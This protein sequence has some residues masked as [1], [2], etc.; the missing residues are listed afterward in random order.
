MEGLVC[1][2]PLPVIF[3]CV[4]LFL[5]SIKISKDHASSLKMSSYWSIVIMYL[6]TGLWLLESDPPWLQVVRWE[7]G[8]V[9]IARAKR[10]FIHQNDQ[11]MFYSKKYMKPFFWKQTR[12][13]IPDIPVWW[14]I[15][16]DILLTK[17]W[18]L[19]DWAK[20]SVRI[21]LSGLNLETISMNL[22]KF[23]E[24]YNFGC[25]ALWQTGVYFCQAQDRTQVKV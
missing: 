5:I 2:L 18:N 19:L 20:F 15:I 21:F 8:R 6:D 25:C 9:F 4:A 23:F 16:D 3:G 14:E 24:S 13:N 10:T 7:R 1:G 22:W 12:L 11:I 17:P